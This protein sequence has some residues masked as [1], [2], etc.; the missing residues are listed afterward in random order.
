MVKQNKFK[1]P[2][3]CIFKHEFYTYILF[4]TC[5]RGFFK[6]FFKI[7]HASKPIRS[8]TLNREKTWNGLTI[9]VPT[10]FIMKLLRGNDT[11]QCCGRTP[12]LVNNSI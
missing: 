12:C 3:T 9:L 6:I 4:G 2:S 1:N 5:M 8:R 10:C 7:F 11:R